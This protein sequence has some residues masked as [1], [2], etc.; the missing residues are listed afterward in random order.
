MRLPLTSYR[1]P[2]PGELRRVL[3]PRRPLRN[4]WLRSP[5]QSGYGMVVGSRADLLRLGALVRLAAVSGHSAVHVPAPAGEPP[6]FVAHWLHLGE[7][8]MDLLIVR[9]DVRLR[10]SAWPRVRRRIHKGPARG[11]PLTAQAPAARSPRSPRPWEKD[12]LISLRAHG[13]ALVLSGSARA[14]HLAGDEL[15]WAGEQI[16]G[17]RAVH[18]HG[19]AIL[20]TLTPLLTGGGAAPQ[21]IEFDIYGCDP[22]FHR[23]RWAG[24]RGARVTARAGR[25]R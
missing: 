9:D 8:P 11:R 2:G 13:T 6:A 22:I 25:R 5:H 7:T 10:P 1:T 4:L 17:D 24:L 12:A 20:G 21:G 14:L 18:R 19:E 3:E 16:P 15:T 23:R